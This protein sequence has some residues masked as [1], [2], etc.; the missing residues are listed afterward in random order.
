LAVL[1]VGFDEFAHAVQRSLS[2]VL[3]N[4]NK[5]T[6]KRN[7]IKM[8]GLTGGRHLLCIESK[9]VN[10]KR[11][12]SIDCTYS[13]ITLLV[14]LDGRETRNLS[15]VQLVGCGINLGNHN[16]VIVLEL[17]SQLQSQIDKIKITQT[18]SI[19]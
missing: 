11:N 3:D 5:F 19:K 12:F 17:L 4:L 15:V 10:W 1:A 9:E 8:F 2:V 13:V 6:H 16:L 14:K 18:I 7:L